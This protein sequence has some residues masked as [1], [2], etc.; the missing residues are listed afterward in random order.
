MIARLEIIDT[1][2]VV[3]VEKKF[4]YITFDV[5]TYTSHP[6]KK[7]K[8]NNRK[9][10]IECGLNARYEY[11]VCWVFAHGRRDAQK[12]GDLSIIYSFC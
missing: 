1:N 3:C 2:R 9:R 8:E 12:T 4:F 6:T 11:D 5:L 7:R 10:I